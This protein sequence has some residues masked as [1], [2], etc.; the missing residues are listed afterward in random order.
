MA[1]L[2]ASEVAK[3]LVEYARRTALAGGNPYRSKAYL[4]AA[5]SLAALAEPLARIVA[6][7]RLQGIP[8]VGDAIADI[9]TKL[10]RT[11]S[12]PSLERMRRE[13]PEGVLE[14]LSVPG[15]RPDKVLKLHKQLGIASLAELE[16]AAREDRIK[17]T[18]GLG[19]ALQR[20]II[21]GLEIRKAALGSRHMHRAA[22]LMA[23]AERNL[24]RAIPGLKRIVAAGDFRRGCELACD[25][26]L[27]AEDAKLE[28]GPEL[29][30]TN[31]LSVYLTDPEHFGSSLLLATGS[32]AHLQQLRTLAENQ[33]LSLTDRGLRRGDK[34]IAA[35]TEAD[36]YKALGLQYIEPELREGRG[37]IALARK[38]LIP[39]LVELKDLR[40]ILHAHTDQSD[41]GNSL[42]EMAEATRKRGYEYFGVADHSQSARYAG[43]LSIEQIR[44]Q[45][46]EIDRLNSRFNGRFRIFK[47]I[48]SDILPDGSLDYPDEIL[49]E[50]DFIVASIHGQFRMDR[51]AQTERL[52]RAVTNPFVTILGHMTGRQL[53]RRS[54]YELDVEKVLKACADHGVAVE[55]N[56]N[57][58]RLDLDWR[59]HQRGL[60]LGCMFSVNPDAHSIAELDLMRWGLAMARKGGVSADRVLNALDLYGF[61]QWL[62]DRRN[63]TAPPSAK[64]G[65]SAHHSPVRSG[66]CA[67]IPP[68]R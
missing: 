53:L 51:E 39:R 4:R 9:I 68:T 6:E 10:H 44:Q 55:I 60:E 59:W 19:P 7:D 29:V 3:L 56:A 18:K 45:H 15:L 49:R 37:E 54:G 17:S 48:E 11:G 64:I 26:S 27:V 36:I 21:Q 12:H 1:P 40:G 25:L 50:F 22:E 24:R 35:K 52:L 66:R 28:N 13:V 31:Q 42:E 8:G 23:A 38:H 58:W 41:G 63:H 61:S 32:D 65:A 14:M 46:A 34:S 2:D 43:G 47:G 20:K 62:A 33:G 16:A 5:E 67:P 57:P 30:K